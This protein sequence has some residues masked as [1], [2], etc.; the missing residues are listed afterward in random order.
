MFQVD[1]FWVVMPCSVVA[2]Y[3]LFILKM[4]AARTSET[5]VSYHN[6]KHR[7]NLVDLDLK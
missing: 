6:N 3:Q 4:D 7:H 1:V 2:E 5:S